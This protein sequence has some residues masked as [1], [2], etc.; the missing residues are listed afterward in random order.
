MA[1][2]RVVKQVIL[3]ERLHNK[4]LR[5]VVPQLCKLK[6]LMQRL[7]NKQLQPVVL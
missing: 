7:H 6:I 4:L 3:T 1:L 5:L 2:P